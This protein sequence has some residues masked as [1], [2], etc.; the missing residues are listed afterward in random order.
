MNEILCCEQAAREKL[1]RESYVLRDGFITF[2]EFTDI[3]SLLF[4]CPDKRYLG[5]E[6]AEKIAGK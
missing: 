5:C 3:F 2:I 4:R 1:L 6:K